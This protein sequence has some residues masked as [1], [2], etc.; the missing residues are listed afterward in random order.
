MITPTKA[1]LVMAYPQ[2]NKE[3][4]VGNK[5]LFGAD[6]E[7]DDLLDGVTKLW[8]ASVTELD[9]DMKELGSCTVTE[10]SD[11]ARLFS[12][13]DHILVMHNGIAYD[14]PAVTKVLGVKVEAEII[15]TLFLSW[16]LYPTRA[17]HGLASH[18]EDLGIPK[19][20]IDDWENL[21]LE[22]YV[23]RCEEDVRIQ[24]ALW[25][26]IW[27]HLNLLYQSTEECWHVIRH[28]N[29]KAKCAAMQEE[30]RWKLDVPK[31]EEASLFFEAKFNMAKVSL[32][33]HMPDVPTYSVKKRPK[34]PFLANGKVS[35]LGQRW[36]GTVR[37]EVSGMKDATEEDALEYFED[38]KLVNGYKEPNAGSSKQIKDML[39]SLGWEPTSFKYNR[40]KETNKT[41][42]IPQVKDPNTELL[43]QSVVDLIPK[44]PALQFLDDMSVVKHRLSVVRGFLNNVSED[45]YVYAAIQGLTNTLRFKHK[46]CLNIPSTR[47]PFGALIRGLL[48]ARDDDHELCGSDMDS[49]EDRTKQHYMWPHDEA[50]VRD[51]LEDGF[52]P[53]TDMAVEAKLMSVED[54]AEYKM[55][56][57]LEHKT[58]DQ[59]AR[60][61]ALSL[62]RH[63]G[64]GTNYAATYGATGPTIARSAGVEEH[65]G[66]VLYE[67][68]WSR[69]W[70][71]KAIADNCI[72]Q[73][74]RGMKWIWNPVA[75]MW[76]YLKADKDKFSTLNQSTGTFCFDRWIFYVIEQ[77]PQLTAQFHDEGI[78]ELMKGN[79]IAM[80]EILKSAM[81][82]VN[83]ELKLNR[84]L[85]CGVDFGDSYA[86]IH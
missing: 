40:N 36:V 8:C 1:T 44:M 21:T 61:A 59:E 27:K 33:K 80:T 35:A 25:K 71:L 38:I 54:V 48:L 68:Y 58:K 60:Y 75:K 26:E 86:D 70:S 6:I 84:E 69:N 51:M 32:E 20:K 9:S 62:I 29:F 57:D 14:G 19:P 42:I 81:V 22:E 30:S 24:T 66:G 17:L 13:P 11:I 41:K 47:K 82:S 78:W 3:H 65:I 23:H 53:H 67:A 7:A 49:L 39:F 64:K 10:D 31:C 73:K 52:D 56:K 83:K 37:S 72:V 63:A 79:R 55:L 28:L 16:Y 77:R 12:N 43:C 5:R 15:D 76:F 18:G 4:T 74:S 50:Y 2:T 46:V 45:G 34:K 85:D